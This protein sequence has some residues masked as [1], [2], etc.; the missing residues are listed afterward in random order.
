[1]TRALGGCRWRAVPTAIGLTEAGAQG[2]REDRGIRMEGL[3]G[4][5]GSGRQ[6]L[7][8]GRP[9]ANASD[10]KKKTK[11][12]QFSVL[13][14]SVFV[15]RPCSTLGPTHLRGWT[16]RGTQSRS[17]AST[18]AQSHSKPRSTRPNRPGSR[19]RAP[20]V[21]IT[22]GLGSMSSDDGH[23]TRSTRARGWCSRVRRA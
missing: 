19:R 11:T 13:L 16:R 18:R 22:H 15:P 21:P 2:S 6:K 9:R 10:T 5:S 14:I 3:V 12:L 1:M 7:G 23:L 4:S 8:C 20:A 17:G